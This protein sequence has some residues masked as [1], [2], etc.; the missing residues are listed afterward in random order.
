MERRDADLVEG[1]PSEPDGGEVAPAE[2]A[3]DDVAAIVVP[4]AN[5]DGVVAT[6]AVIVA[7]FV[8]G[9]RH[10]AAVAA[11]PALHA[12]G[13]ARLAAGGV[14]LCCFLPSLLLARHG[15]LH[16]LRLCLL[17]PLLTS[18]NP[19]HPRMRNPPFKASRESGRADDDCKAVQAWPG[20]M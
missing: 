6:A 13:L 12:A 11:V 3:V 19:V 8:L 9:F 5:A 4:I 1:V 20:G 7:A 10:I 16:W 18:H 15:W 17:L 14:L 2:L